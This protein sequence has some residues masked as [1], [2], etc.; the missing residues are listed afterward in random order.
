MDKSKFKLMCG[1]KD[2]NS[3]MKQALMQGNAQGNNY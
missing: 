1:I 2:F 3:Q